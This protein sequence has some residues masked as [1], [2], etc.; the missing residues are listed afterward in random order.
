MEGFGDSFV[1]TLGGG[2][3]AVVGGLRLFDAGVAGAGA[4]EA[5][6]M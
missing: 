1:A 5:A 6:V 2:S 4:V 3:F